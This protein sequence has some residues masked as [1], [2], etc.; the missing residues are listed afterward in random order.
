MK[1][2]LLVSD[3]AV[4]KDHGPVVVQSRITSARSRLARLRTWLAR[5]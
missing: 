5:C 2:A 4:L 3:F 1:F